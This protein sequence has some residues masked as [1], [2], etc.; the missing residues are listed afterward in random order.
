MHGISIGLVFLLSK[1]LDIPK[2]VFG[3]GIWITMVGVIVFIR[4]LNKYPVEPTPTS[5]HKTTSQA[6]DGEIS[7]VSNAS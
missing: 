1:T 6:E 7:E 5:G 3:L 2:L 4:Y